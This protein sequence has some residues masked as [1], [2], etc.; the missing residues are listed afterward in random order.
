MKYYTGDRTLAMLNLIFH[1]SYLS[2]TCE[3]F[4][5]FSYTTYL[6]QTHE[7]FARIHHTFANVTYTCGQFRNFNRYEFFTDVIVIGACPAL[8]CLCPWTCPAPARSLAHH[9]PRPCQ[10]LL[11]LSFKYQM[12]RTYDN[13][14]T[15]WMICVWNKGNFLGVFKYVL[16][17]PIKSMSHMCDKY[18]RILWRIRT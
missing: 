7:D 8:P 6:L 1:T 9:G 5:Y 3:E 12:L 15:M 11:M 14:L 16:M 18:V 4:A 13:S 17:L 2:R 10:L